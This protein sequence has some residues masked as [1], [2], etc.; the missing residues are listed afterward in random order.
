MS[1]THYRI[2]CIDHQCFVDGYGTD[3]P[4]KC[5]LVETHNINP[6]S[7]QMMEQYSTQKVLISEEQGPFF[8]GGNF[9]V[10]GFDFE[11]SPNATTDYITNFPFP[12]SMLMCQLQ[13]SPDMLMDKVDFISGENTTIGI[14]TQVAEIGNTTINV[15]TSVIKYAYIG[16]YLRITDGVNESECARI[17][18]IDPVALTVKFETALTYDFAQGSYFQVSK[19]FVK[20]YKLIS[21]GSHQMGSSKIGGGYVSLGVNGI[22]RYTNTS[23]TTKKISFSIEYLY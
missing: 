16:L 8:T 4:T 9:A 21:I 19:Y 14:I 13:V 22:C 15:S 20:N 23:N 17:I 6:D 5:Y 2:Y 10:A 18:A 3:P 7:V 12:I 1:I 11:A